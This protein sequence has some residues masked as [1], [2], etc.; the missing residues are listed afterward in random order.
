MSTIRKFYPYAIV[1]VACLVIGALS[2]FLSDPIGGGPPL[3]EDELALLEA[4]ITELET[5]SSAL[6]AENVLLQTALDSHTNDRLAHGEIQVADLPQHQHDISQIVN[7]PEYF[8]EEQIIDL[9]G[10]YSLGAADYDSGWVNQPSE[11]IIFQ[12]N[13]GTKDVF[14]YVLGKDKD[15]VNGWVH[16]INFDGKDGVTWYADT[17]DKILLLRNTDEVYWNEVRVLIWKLPSPPT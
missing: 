9:I 10:M 17:I 5:I 2:I 4:R 8:T 7:H 3:R 1:F 16:Q 6:E 11:S 12:H 13:L 14:V 15:A